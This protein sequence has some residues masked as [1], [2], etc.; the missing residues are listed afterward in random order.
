MWRPLA[1]CALAFA[2]SG[3]GAVLTRTGRAGYVLSSLRLPVTLPT[4]TRNGPLGLEARRKLEE[5]DRLAS[6]SDRGETLAPLADK[7]GLVLLPAE[8]EGRAV[9]I[10]AAPVRFA[11]RLLGLSPRAKDPEHRVGTAAQL[12]ESVV[13][14]VRP[15]QDRLDVLRGLLERET[16]VMVALSG[17]GARAAAFARHVMAQLEETY[18]DV[19]K[20][21][22]A[23]NEAASLFDSIDG[24]SSV[25][26]GSI[27]LSHVAAWSTVT[28]RNPDDKA[29]SSR[30]FGD[31][32]RIPGPTLGTSYLGA[33]ASLRYFWP[34]NLAA[35]LGTDWTYLDLLAATLK[36][37]YPVPWR[38]SHLFLT[39]P[40]LRLGDLP[41]QPRFFFNATCLETGTP[42]VI[43][44]SLLHLPSETALPLE[45]SLRHWL[46]AAPSAPDTENRPWQDFPLP[47]ALTLE[48]INSSPAKFPLA[49][50]A[51]A[52]ASFPVLQDPLRVRKYDYVKSCSG[53]ASMERLLL[54]LK[55]TLTGAPPPPAGAVR[56]SSTL[57]HLTDGGVYDNSG[58]CT[59]VSLF[60][61]LVRKGKA[62]RLV[63]LQISAENSEYDANAATRI[64]RSWNRLAEL[65]P[66][67]LAPIRGLG[68][69]YRS[70]TLMNYLNERRA[71]QEALGRLNQ[72]V[73][74][75]RKATGPDRESQ[76]SYLY[77]PVRLGRLSP[78]ALQSVQS[79]EEIFQRVQKIPTD[80][81]I[82]P[83]ND[84]C[85]AKVAAMVLTTP[86]RVQPDAEPA[87]G[88][89]ADPTGTSPRTQ[90]HTSGPWR[91]APGDAAPTEC[92]D[93]AFARA[94]LRSREARPK[95]NAQ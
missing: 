2:L 67:S 91:L 19:R 25:S 60:E 86:C 44:Q 95:P 79:D 10:L 37:T 69:A 12:A 23:S 42:F 20:Q 5:V 45:M 88:A 1:L 75:S 18:N 21:S 13:G 78:R 83:E 41:A 71:E 61:Y 47:G 80:F 77:F 48:D 56:T 28:G 87:P 90:A 81:T 73:S 63:L 46:S 94:V 55:R 68:G 76:V 35:M 59:I 32:D 17:G 31:L 30:A 43:T 84:E 39:D 57:L 40:G 24:Y 49:Y 74:E 11:R 15:R 54:P 38:L 85:L 9:R 82:T 6:A 70:L 33:A 27:Y 89:A 7:D 93:I 29:Q 14:R 51:M 26:G 62:K 34:L 4:G 50:A 53:L 72:L 58:M 8:E 22:G 52:S 92:L 16:V 64:G 36:M 65:V 66:E 3:C